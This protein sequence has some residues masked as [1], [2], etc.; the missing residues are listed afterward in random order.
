MLYREDGASALV[1]KEFFDWM[2]EWFTDD[3]VVVYV[4]VE[5]LRGYV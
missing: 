4:V 1:M 2:F 3:C 5:D